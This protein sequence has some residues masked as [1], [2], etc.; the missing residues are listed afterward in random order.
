MQ[1]AAEHTAKHYPEKPLNCR[2]FGSF[3]TA[4]P[5][6]TLTA[7]N[8]GSRNS[9]RAA[10]SVLDRPTGHLAHCAHYVDALPMGN[11]LHDFNVQRYLSAA[12]AVGAWG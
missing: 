7:G 9:A 8:V 1:T 2:G 6:P 12:D 5:C 10:I 11:S 4:S 3:G